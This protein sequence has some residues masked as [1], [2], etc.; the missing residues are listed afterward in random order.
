MLGLGETEEEIKNTLKDLR[1]I[2]CDVVTFG[3]YLR[4]SRRHL[5]VQ[6]Y[7]TPQGV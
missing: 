3:Q 6:K 4:P 7:L 5:P 1:Q 2:A